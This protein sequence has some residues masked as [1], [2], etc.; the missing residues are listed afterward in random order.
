M[1]LGMLLFALATAVPGV[2][3]DTD[4]IND[5]RV[6]V[7]VLT[8]PSIQERV[9]APSGTGANYDWSDQRRLNL[10]F[11]AMYLQGMSRRGR[12]IGGFIWG[13]GALYG[14]ADV[15]PGSYDTAGGSFDNTRS[16]LG[17]RYREYGLA[18]AAGV[19]TAPS[20]T[21]LGS[22]TWEL[23]PVVRGG[24]AKLDTVTPGFTSRVES[25]SAWFYEGGVRGGLVL[26]DNNFLLGLHLGYV[27][28]KSRFSIG[29]GSV[30]DS[31]VLVVRKGP[32]AG[33]DVGVRF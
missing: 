25:D 13:V 1:R 11:E 30:G 9:T 4:P 22:L 31:E 3:A 23:L 5:I 33:L 20:Q 16:D 6:G 32:E 7:S 15:T 2:A 17:L 19:A 8:A 18:L 27:Y 12:G 24:L 28:G 14:N 10:R 26:A 29:M 21:S